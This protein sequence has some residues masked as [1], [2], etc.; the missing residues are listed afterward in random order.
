MITL[1]SAPTVYTGV[2]EA[3]W[4]AIKN[5]DLNLYAAHQI[6]L[7]LEDNYGA[8]V[9]LKQRKYI[10]YYIE[11]SPGSL[12]VASGTMSETL[13]CDLRKIEPPQFIIIDNLNWMRGFKS[14]YDLWKDRFP[15]DMFRTGVAS[16]IVADPKIRL[17]IYTYLSWVS[18][19]QRIN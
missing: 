18:A 8:F 6:R 13:G 15:E 11:Q 7:I 9:P 1:K 14:K 17:R 10:N 16:A 3:V 19:N 2:L 5:S 12:S 4:D